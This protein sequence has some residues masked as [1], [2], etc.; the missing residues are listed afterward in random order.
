MGNTP[1]ISESVLPAD[2]P[3]LHPSVRRYL[4]RLGN[5]DFILLPPFFARL[6]VNA[7]CWFTSFLEPSR[8]LRRVYDERHSFG[9][10]RIYLP[11][12]APPR[13]ILLYLHGGGFV[14]CGVRTH[15]GLCR[16][17]ASVGGFAVAS[18]EYRL[19]P[20]HAFP[21][22][23][24]DVLAAY[25]HLRG[26]AGSEIVG[27]GPVEVAVGGDSAGGNLAASL[28]L[29]LA[30]GAAGDAEGARVAPLPR[31]AA[32]PQPFFS[33]L[34]YP[35]VDM[36]AKSKS[37]ARYAR[38]WFL[39]AR[40]KEYFWGHFLGAPG[41]ARDALARLPLL[42]PLVARSELLAEAPPTLVLT[43]EHD[44]LHDEGVAFA[45]ALRAAAK[46]RAVHHVEGAGL[47]HGFAN[48]LHVGPAAKAVEDAAV[49]LRALDKEVRGGT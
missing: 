14:F 29:A 33:F 5:A 42:S 27:G 2:V 16:T 11:L 7:A 6:L 21:S 30:M 43:A 34:I 13:T 3:D 10:L 26:A 31:L 23:Q 19:A 48:A 35:A 4:S 24:R 44:I 17:L 28:S 37:H 49:R 40:M 38:G 18:L 36:T 45:E 25:E 39:S 9:R 15:D 8:P 1:L 22:A 12:G 47:W 46:H 20:E 41:P 32:L